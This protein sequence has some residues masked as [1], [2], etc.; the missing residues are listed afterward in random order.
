MEDYKFRFAISESKKQYSHVNEFFKDNLLDLLS[1]CELY[2]QQGEKINI[3]S[4]RLKH[5]GESRTELYSDCRERVIYNTENTS[6]SEDEKAV[7]ATEPRIAYIMKLIKNLKGIVDFYSK[8][9]PCLV[10]SVVLKDCAHW[11]LK[12]RN[13]ASAVYQYLAAT[14]NA[15]CK[16]CYLQANPTNIRIG[17]KACDDDCSWNELST[18]IKYFSQEKNLFSTSYEIKEFFNS[19]YFEETLVELRKKCNDDFMFVT[20]GSLLTEEKIKFLSTVMPV[21]LIISVVVISE[22]KR[23]ELLFNELIDDEREKLNQVMM[24]SFELL[25]K[26]KVPFIGSI[27]AWPT[28]KY[29]DFIETIRYLEQFNPVAIR[30]N[31]LGYTEKNEPTIPVP[32]SFWYDFCSY[33]EKASKETEVPLIPIPSQYYINEFQKDILDVEVLGVIKNSPA[34]GKIKKGDVI[35]KI[36]GMSI[37]SRDQFLEAL[38]LL[39]GEKKISLEREGK[40]IE[41]ALGDENKEVYP[42][43]GTYYGKYQFPYGIVIPESIQMKQIKKIVRIIEENDK[44]NALLIVGPLVKKTVIRYF[45]M[46]GGN[47]DADYAVVTLKGRCIKIVSSKNYFLGGNMR[48]MDMCVISDFVKIVDENKNEMTDMVILPDSMFNIWGNDLLG[49]NK[50]MFEHCIGI[51]VEYFSAKTVPY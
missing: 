8:D 47:V 25:N 37:T 38:N 14:C 10:D 40:G 13:H 28:I 2:D 23:G 20:N 11:L 3:S 51:P 26:Y 44:K 19:P 1:F 43:A 30:I 41:I 46:L 16:F 31:M 24:K 39:K 7:D 33:I 35:K 15:N 45:E 36:N 50:D 29:S 17:K 49:V 32:E 12:E 5:P 9:E 42:Y 27:T 21:T 48:I 18:R 4:F 34:C 6:L 22:K